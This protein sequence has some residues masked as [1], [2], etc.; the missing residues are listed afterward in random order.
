M[1]FPNTI[2]FKP[3]CAAALL[4]LL[5]AL[6]AAPPAA[7]QET[8][9]IAGTI[10]D[11][12][13]GETLIGASAVVV[14]TTTGS[15]ADLDG[16]YEITGLEPGTYDV[17]FS[18]TGFQAQTVEGVEVTVGETTTVDATLSSES[19][20]LDEVTVTAE[21][22]RNSEAG[23]LKSRQK[24]SGVSDAISAETISQSGSSNAADAMEKVTGAS[25]RDGKY[26]TVRG[27][28]GRYSNTTLNGVELPSSDPE[29]KA[30]QF[31]LFSADLLDNIVTLKT[32]T[33]DRPG[34]FSGGLV[35]IGTKSFPGDLNVTV[36]SSVSFSPQVQ[37]SDDFLTYPGGEWDWLAFDDGSRDIPSILRGVSPGTI[38]DSPAQ[39]DNPGNPQEAALANDL[40]R[41]SRSFN[42]TMAPTRSTAP[43]DQSYSLSLGNQADLFGRSLGY[44]MSLS[45]SR[46]SS[47]Y[48]NGETGRYVFRGQDADDLQ[49]RIVLDDSKGS[50][51]VNIGGL[52]NFA[53]KITPSNEVTL[54]AL[55]SRSG[56]SEARL[57]QGRW[58]ELGLNDENSTLFNRTLEYTQRDLY[59]F[60]LQGEHF[61]PGL[62]NSTIEWDGAYAQTQQNQPDLRFFASTR[63]VRPAQGDTVYSGSSS[64]FQ[65]PSRLYRD[66]DE[67]RASGSADVTIPFNFL[68]GG[69]G[70][71]KFGGLYSQ[72]DRDFGERFFSFNGPEFA[73][74]IRFDGDENAYFS[75]ANRGIVG[76]DSRGDYIYG[77][78]VDDQTNP[79]NNYTGELNVAAGYLMAEVPITKSLRAIGGVRL[80]TTDL[81][82]VSQDSSGAIN[83]TD[84]LPS[85]NLVYEIG[86]NMNIRVAS[87]RT[88]ARP[89][90]R[91]IAPFSSF[92]YILG[93]L[94][95]G[96][97]ALERTLI[98]NADVRWEWFTRPGEILA[99]SGFYKHL[100]NPIERTIL[101]TNRQIKYVNVPSAQIFGAEF[102][103]RTQLDYFGNAFR[104][105]SVGGNLSLVQSSIDIPCEVEG[106]DGECQRGELAVRRTIDPDA[107]STRE[108]QGQ[109][110]YLINL[111]L[112]YEN[113]D[114][115]TSVGL[116]FD[117]FGERL[118]SVSVG[119]TS[120]VY[121]QP[122][123]GLDLTISQSFMGAWSVKAKAKN[124]LGSSYEEVYKFNDREF[125]FQQYE[126][127]RS[128]SLGL[129]YTP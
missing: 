7:A 30:V 76:T 83:T 114:S 51:E 72:T 12:E 56:T 85:L 90:F 116:F 43:I 54:N 107:E 125:V 88:L 84:L 124:M 26:V 120:D 23:L 113:P 2:R 97:P 78:S 117:V 71:L 60:Q 87:T 50:T 66:L 19:V 44:V 126:L 47:F 14:G 58:F 64:G 24:A 33:P 9:A 37:F 31:D 41:F 129:T 18:Y 119:G 103:A 32:F 86:E 35:D 96:N 4:L 40:D 122:R 100:E 1:R 55:Y 109:S 38:P 73:S 74:G 70:N 67:T 92:E 77:L 10:V 123:P 20:G 45:Y 46:S 8:G 61:L 29:Q 118:S 16:R 48:E 75:E 98:T 91:E 17:R 13:N 68:P 59:S 34:N 36:S 121:E 112:S 104:H 52:A 80:E 22:A 21:A 105:F 93:E 108:L 127:G 99:V 128:F 57:Q 25:V 81:S 115:G 11:D 28:G 110:P 15:A 6:L 82:V 62:L 89:T 3:L 39:A 101:G 94:F 49:G 63:V 27:L 42:G 65:D 53:Y 5:S 79:N 102:E 69:R 111:N 95:N 106:S